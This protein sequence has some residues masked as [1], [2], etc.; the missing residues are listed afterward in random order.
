ML[1]TG[2]FSATVASFIT[3]SYQSLS[4]DSSDTTNA[5]LTQI[6][7]Q[8]VNISNGTPLTSIV[9]QSNHPFK[10]TASAVRVNVLWFLSLILSLSCA[11]SATLMQQ[12]ARRYQELARRR[13]AFHRRA[14][15]RAYIFDGINSFGMTRAVATMPTLLHISVF[16]FF[17]GLID[18][19]FPIYATVAYATFGCIGVF[20]LAYAILTVLPNIYLN[21]PYSTP[22]SGFTW[23]GFQFSAFGFLWTILTIDVLFRNTVS[24][25]LDVANQRVMIPHRLKMWRESLEMKV[26]IHRQWFSQSLRR[27][28][29][30]RAYR[31]ESRVITSALEWTL[32]IL[33]EEKEIEDFTARVPGFFDSRADPDATSAVLSLMSHQPNTDPIFGSRLCDL[34]EICIPGTSLIDDKARKCRMRVCLNCLWHFGRAYNQ[35]GV[36]QLLPSFVHNSLLPEITR[37]V[38]IEEDS[39]IRVMGRCVVAVIINKFA[40]DLNSRTILVNDELLSSL[41]SIL[42]TKSYD[43]QFLL[44]Q[45][46]S[47]A[48]AN[49]I[50]FGFGEVGTFVADE[51]PPDVLDMVKQTLAILSQGHLSLEDAELQVEETVAV[52]RNSNGKFERILVSRLF[53]LLNT[54]IQVPSPLTEGVRMSSL[55]MCLTG[56][57]YFGQGFNWLGNSAP[58][59]LYICA[60]FTPELIR[61]VRQHRDLAIRVIGR[62]VG[63][64]VVNKLAANLNS[65]ADPF[66]EVELRCLSVVLGI[67][68]RDVDLFLRQPGAVSLSNHISLFFD[69]AG[70]WVT[71]IVPSDV[72]GIVQQTFTTLSPAL[73]TQEN[74]ELQPEHTT[75]IQNGSY[76]EYERILV[77]QLLG[78]LNTCIQESSSLPEEVRTRCLRMCLKGMW[79]FGRA[80]NQLGNSVPLPSYICAAFTPEMICG[81][82]RQ[83]D[84][85]VRLLGRCV[86]ALVVSKLAANLNSLNNSIKDV[87]LECLSAIF[88]DEGHSM[89]LL[90]R[91]PGAVAL[92]DFISLVFDEV[93]TWGMDTISSDVLDVVQKTLPI[94]SRALSAQERAELQLEQTIAIFNGSNGKFGHILVPRLLELI[95]T[96]IRETSLR[97]E[98]L[99]TSCLRMCLKGLWHLTKE[100][101]ERG[102]S[103]S[104]PSYVY[105]AFNDLEMTHY[106]RQK[107]DLATRMIGRCVEAFVVNKLTADIRLHSASNAKLACLSAI[108]GT[109]IDDVKLLLR[110]PHAIDLQ[111]SF[112]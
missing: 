94:L 15:M 92:S 100:Y 46:G 50:S 68:G 110:H 48:L 87:E 18:F 24:N 66:S 44:L 34:L 8:L 58:L 85:S 103:M 90:L 72:L 74:V 47:V 49:M 42:G 7:Q 12:W 63:A 86:W 82:Q 70:T 33:D 53:D 97:P 39:T 69:D 76:K 43:L 88:G 54:C 31:A 37:R 25:V 79:Y 40:T 56:L 4:P 45:P 51:I 95:N 65:R 21:C 10:P 32:T 98:E 14:R 106:I 96:C 108:L 62:C 27:S 20:A 99:R 73:S 41:S 3:E 60:A 93:G 52:F 9:P 107:T 16:F 17:A 29:E 105:V 23:H 30:I 81:I 38:Q 26:K 11:L 109:R 84:L 2:L 61:G 67:K 112:S 5:L 75:I 55:R 19:L 59:P 64:M 77:S 80:F 111:T 35:P 22:L 57:W 36:S 78:T 102:N 83:H 6:S 89:E 101:N 104:L 13:G 1:K 71:D 91:R 28:V